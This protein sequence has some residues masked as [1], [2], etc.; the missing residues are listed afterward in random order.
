MRAVL[1]AL[2]ALSLQGA[3]EQIVH[4]RLPSG[5][6]VSIVEAPFRGSGISVQGCEKSSAVCRIGGKPYGLATGVPHTYVRSIVATYGTSSFSL[7]SSGIYDAE[8]P[9]H[10][11]HRQSRFFGGSCQDEKNCVFRAVFGDAANAMAAEWIVM[12][13]V[14]QRTVLTGDTDLIEFFQTNIDPP[15]YE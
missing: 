14:V 3:K 10:A 15:V 12:D 2:L 11:S 8:A 4:L 5:I 6:Q 1:L 7:D 9:Q 13:G